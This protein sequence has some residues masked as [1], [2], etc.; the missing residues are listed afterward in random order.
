MSKTSSSSCPS[1]PHPLPVSPASGVS[2]TLYPGSKLETEE[3][4][5]IPSW[6]LHPLPVYQRVTS[7][8]FLNSSTFLHLCLYHVITGCHNFLCSL[9]QKTPTWPLL[10]CWWP[11]NQRNLSEQQ[12]WSC[13]IPFFTTL[14][15]TSFSAALGTKTGLLNLISKATIVWPLFTPQFHLTALFP[16]ASFYLW[17]CSISVLPRA[18]AQ[19]F[20]LLVIPSLFGSFLH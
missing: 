12:I 6:S 10:P 3:S 19:A 1:R 16:P 4:S 15:D 9:L 20:L 8:Y 7:K 14:I 18:F 2:T 11:Q 5:N 17:A 13:H